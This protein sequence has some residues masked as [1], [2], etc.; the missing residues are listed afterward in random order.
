MPPE[1]DERTNGRLD[2]I[3]RARVDLAEGDT[4]KARHR[5][6]G[7]LVDRPDS[8]EARRLLAEAYRADGY[9]DEAGRWGYL[10]ADAA[11]ADERA[12]YEHGCKHRL[13]PARAAISIRSGLHWP[14]GTAA[15]TEF[16]LKALEV[17]DAQAA[18]E[19]RAWQAKVNPAPAHIA[20]RAARHQRNAE[21]EKARKARRRQTPGSNPHEP[22]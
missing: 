18:V 16:T 12:A 15:P 17:L 6:K 8:M 9:A 2:A 22:S 4:P 20:A 21:R 14:P 11:T 1:A 5:L 3:G 13:G 10:D 7:F 19:H